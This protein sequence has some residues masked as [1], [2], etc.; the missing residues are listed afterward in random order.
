[1][2]VYKNFEAL[3]GRQIRTELFKGRVIDVIQCIER[4]NWSDT[5]DYSDYRDT[6]VTYALVWL[7]EFNF[8]PRGARVD[9][10]GS[11]NSWELINDR[12]S[13]YSGP[14]RKLEIFEQFAYVDCTNLFSYRDRITLT[15]VEDGAYGTFGEPIMWVNYETFKAQRKYHLAKLVEAQDKAKAE[16]D[17]LLQR[18]AAGKAAARA[19]RDAKEA[20]SKLK[21]EAVEAKLPS[22]GTVVKFQGFTGK[23]FWKGCKKYRGVWSARVGIKN[24]AGEIKW[25]DGEQVL[26]VL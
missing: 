15:A 19:K 18:T 4:R 6:N 23:I 8:P 14:K 17:E 2:P 5:L 12:E 11:A 21:A 24:V 3:D 26:S 1:M 13:E 20:Q 10:V 22:R 9:Q 25:L 7:G 16:R